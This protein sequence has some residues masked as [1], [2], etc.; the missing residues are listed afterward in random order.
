MITG[1]VKVSSL[2]K[3]KRRARSVLDDKHLPKIPP[4]VRIDNDVS[5]DYTVVEIY[6]RDRLGLL[7]TVSSELT[8][9]GLFIHIAKVTT[10]GGEAADIF[11]VKDIFGQKIFYK[12]RLKEIIDS[13]FEVISEGSDEAKKSGK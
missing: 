3:K 5:E 10:K 7:Y 2:L 9:L 12:E 8:R 1:K 11:Y 6:T 4:R 13:V